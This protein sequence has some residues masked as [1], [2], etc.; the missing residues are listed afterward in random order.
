MKKF[1]RSKL[2]NDKEYFYEITPYYDPETK[3]IKQKSK[4]LGKNVGGKPIKIREK[5]PLRAYSYGSLFHLWKSLM[6]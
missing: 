3:R 6:N 1:I 4:Y 2:I 5:L